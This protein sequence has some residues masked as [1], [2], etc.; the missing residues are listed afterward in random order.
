[1]AAPNLAF[2]DNYRAIKVRLWTPRPVA[3]P[4][5]VAPEPEPEPEKPAFIMPPGVTPA[6]RVILREVAAK[7]GVDRQ[8]IIGAT[9]KLPVL[10]ARKELCRR[11][12]AELNMSLSTIGAKIGRDHT[13]VLNLISGGKRQRR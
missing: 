11:M 12:R 4:A 13:S 1:M 9:R 5:P 3:P 2:L 8:E 10:A 7:H 6:W